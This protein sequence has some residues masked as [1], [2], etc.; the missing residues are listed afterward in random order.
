MRNQM[1][2]QT[3]ALCCIIE[4]FSIPFPSDTDTTPSNINHISRKSQQGSHC[5]QAH[6]HSHAYRYTHIQRNCWLISDLSET[7]E[8]RRAFPR[9]YNT[10]LINKNE[11]I[12]KQFI[13]DVYM[14][15]SEICTNIYIHIWRWGQENANGKRLPKQGSIASG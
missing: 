4:S 13:L 15:Q 1:Q 11:K 5:P 10:E 7:Y 6:V 3:F 14:C 9:H 8:A 12:Q 2:N